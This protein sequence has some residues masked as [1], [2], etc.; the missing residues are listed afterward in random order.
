MTGQDYQVIQIVHTAME[1]AFLKRLTCSYFIPIMIVTA[2]QETIHMMVVVIMYHFK[3]PRLAIQ[4]N[5]RSVIVPLT[6]APLMESAIVDI[7]ERTTRGII[8]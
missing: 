3:V 7:I 2:G 6:T 5:A 8:N 4:V 1:T